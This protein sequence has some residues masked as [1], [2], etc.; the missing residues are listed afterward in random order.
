ML[1]IFPSLAGMSLTKLYLAGNNMIFPRQGGLISDIMAGDGK[2][3][4]LFFTVNI[5]N[6]I[7]LGQEQ[8]LSVR[9]K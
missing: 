9:Y 8:Y 7:C 4:Y 3:A 5:N 2:I 6:N 1:K